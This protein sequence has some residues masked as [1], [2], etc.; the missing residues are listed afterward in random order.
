MIGSELT[1][2]NYQ[3]SLT[4]MTAND[5][6]PNHQALERLIFVSSYFPFFITV[7]YAGFTILIPLLCPNQAQ[8]SIPFHSNRLRQLICC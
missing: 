2:M 4:K 3:I 1:L 6:L 5:S 8:H 7:L